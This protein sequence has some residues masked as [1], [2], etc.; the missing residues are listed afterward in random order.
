MR[1][2]EYE[3]MIPERPLRSMLETSDGRPE[4]TGRLAASGASVSAFWV[5]LGAVRASLEAAF[6][7]YWFVLGPWWASLESSWRCNDAS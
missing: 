3:G 1:E 7:P 2:C 6:G 4:D 5:P